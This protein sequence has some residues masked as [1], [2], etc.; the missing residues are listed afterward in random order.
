MER[1]L[2]KR[3][4]CRQGRGGDRPSPRTFHSIQET[5]LHSARQGKGTEGDPQVDT[6]LTS[7]P[8]SQGPA[9]LPI[10]NPACSQFP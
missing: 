2:G 7:H 9:P 5:D 3:K 1:L 10:P 8:G 4:Q 6:N